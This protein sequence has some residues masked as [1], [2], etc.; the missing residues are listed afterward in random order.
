M[1]SAINQMY[2]LNGPAGEIAISADDTVAIQMAM[3]FET[4]CLGRSVSEV[5]SKYGYSPSRYYQIQ[6]KF[7]AG[8]SPAL[9]LKKTG[10]KR[11]S[12]RT[13]NVVTQVVRYRF[14]D[15]D[16]TCEVIAQKLRQQNIKVSQRSVERVIETYGLQKKTL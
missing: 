14:L 3:L 1:K 7:R 11:H 5:A 8:G 4:N 13:E 9:C 6:R 16:T 2:S 12:V 10:P 15:P